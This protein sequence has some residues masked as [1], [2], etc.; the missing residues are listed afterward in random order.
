MDVRQATELLERLDNY[1]YPERLAT[2]EIINSIVQAGPLGTNLAHGLAALQKANI[3]QLYKNILISNLEHSGSLGGALARLKQGNLLEQEQNTILA[4]LPYASKIAAGLVILESESLR[5]SEKQYIIN[6]P[7]NAVSIAMGLVALEKQNILILERNA[8]ITAGEHAS[9]IG[10]G[11]AFLATHGVREQFR[12]D[13]INAGSQAFIR[14]QELVM[15]NDRAQVMPIIRVLLIEQAPEIIP[16]ANDIMLL[17]SNPDEF[18]QLSDMASPVFDTPALSYEMAHSG[19]QI[20]KMIYLYNLL[21]KTKSIPENT[22]QI[23]ISINNLIAFANNLNKSSFGSEIFLESNRRLLKIGIDRLLRRNERITKDQDW[24]SRQLLLGSFNLISNYARN[25]PHKSD[26]IQKLYTAFVMGI[27]HIIEAEEGDPI[28][29][30]RFCTTAATIGFFA[31]SEDRADIT[32]EVNNLD[33]I[34]P[35]CHGRLKNLSVEL[36]GLCGYPKTLKAELDLILF[37]LPAPALDFLRTKIKNAIDADLDPKACEI[38]QT[39]S[40]KLLYSL[41]VDNNIL[42]VLIAVSADVTPDG[43]TKLECLDLQNKINPDI[44][45]LDSTSGASIYKSYRTVA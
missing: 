23:Q 40:D 10:Q 6:N 4:N 9:V 22:E 41:G 17:T 30:D 11:L 37:N 36:A 20:R 32:N 18:Y 34:F 13:I 24:G 39:R 29:T 1:D 5:R 35:R 2:P 21:E 26:V 16:S 42:G 7:E 31:S 33:N 38:S 45:K 14:A 8:V 25:N 19:P 15:A 43:L 44:D 28:C 27:R 3:L 12:E